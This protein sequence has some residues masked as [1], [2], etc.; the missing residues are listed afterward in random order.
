MLAKKPFLLII[1]DDLPT[2]K[3]YQREL[4]ADYHV[5]ICQDGMQAEKFL[6]TLE[7]CAV[8]LEPIMS[9]GDGW[10]LISAMHIS[11][12]ARRFPII[13]CSSSDEKKRGLQQGAAVFM[14]KPVLPGDLRDTLQRVLAGYRG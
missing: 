5:V 9:N 12:E 14:T 10:N 2:L 13:L 4:S 1:D 3:L 6:Q 11:G 7:L 8:I